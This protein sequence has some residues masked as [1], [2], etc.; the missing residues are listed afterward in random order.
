MTNL[1]E[2]KEL[3]ARYLS[4]TI[5][6]IKANRVNFNDGW[7]DAGLTMRKLTGFGTK[8]NCTLCKAVGDIIGKNGIERVDCDSCAW[9]EFTQRMC[10]NGI[11]RESYNNIEFAESENEL[12]EAIQVRGEYMTEL[13][14]RD[15]GV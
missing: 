13:I 12:L 11:N 3:A 7:I 6:E 9:I 1:K 8:T 10:A 15:R 4:I 5:D 14:E 2:F